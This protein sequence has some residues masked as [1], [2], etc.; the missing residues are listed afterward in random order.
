MMRQRPVPQKKLDEVERLK[1]LVEKYKVIGLAH[2]EKMPANS[3]QDL[4][5]NL[6]KDVVIHVSKKRLITRAFA[7]IDK[8]NLTEF[9]K[10][11]SGI[12][13]LLFT[14]MDPIKLAKYLQSKATKGAAK[15]GDIAPADIIVKEGDTKLPPGPIVSDFA[16]FL[17][18]QTMVKNGTI[19]IRADT[20]THKAGQVILA[21]EAELL[22]R[23]GLTPMDIKLDLYGAWNDGNI[24]PAAL[25]HLDDAKITADTRLAAS[26]AFSLAMAIGVITQET[27]VP[28]I[29]KGARIARSVAM[30]LPIVIPELANDYIAKAVREAN[31]IQKIVPDSNKE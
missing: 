27:A 14:D 12:T 7:E 29:T 5:Q 22:T 11:L 3:L 15:P 10:N 28:L 30:K 8:P 13:A 1:R 25:L 9:L 18:V 23:L 19:H 4:R 6:R 17:K 31:A 26:Q 20:V 16:Q 24:V 2:L 21:K